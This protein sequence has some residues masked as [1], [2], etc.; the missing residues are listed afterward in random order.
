M[1]ANVDLTGEPFPPPPCEM[2]TRFPMGGYDLKCR[3]C[4]ARAYVRA[5]EVDQRQARKRWCETLDPDS[6]AEMQRLVAEERLRQD[7]AR[8]D[9]AKSIAAKAAA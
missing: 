9:R 4:E 2:C 1:S 5:P 7:R 6:I 3:R 8:I